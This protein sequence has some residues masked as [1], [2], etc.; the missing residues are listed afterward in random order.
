MLA[1]L[2][3]HP[4]EQA[5]R[6]SVELIRAVVEMRAVKS[7][8]ELAEIENAVDTTVDMHLEAM[9]MARPGMRESD[10]AATGHRDRPRRRRRTSR[11]R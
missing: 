10:I 5:A 3:I 4:E 2:D 9:K 8:E 7:V 1:L 11:S 6:A